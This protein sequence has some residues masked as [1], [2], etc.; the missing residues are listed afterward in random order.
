MSNDI[1]QD[2]TK[3]SFTI[4][5][6]GKLMGVI[7]GHQRYLLVQPL[8]SINRVTLDEE[9]IVRVQQYRFASINIP[10]NEYCYKKYKYG[11]FY[12]INDTSTYLSL[13]KRT[14][15][16]E[17]N[18]SLAYNF[19]SEWEYPYLMCIVMGHLT[20]YKIL[21]E[22]IDYERGEIYNGIDGDDIKVIS[23]SEV[24]T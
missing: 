10:I 22:C 12:V 7:Q 5:Q 8:T 20:K 24:N 14:V 11:D 21:G 23:S 6:E 4:D 19:S 17:I 9:R 3:V 16:V 18:E 2:G 1:I 15:P 13:D